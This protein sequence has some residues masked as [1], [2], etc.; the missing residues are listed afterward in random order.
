MR[1]V[2]YMKVNFQNKRILVIDDE[3][4]MLDIVQALLK[5]HDAQPFAAPG[6]KKGLQMACE[7]FD[8][9]ILDRYMPDGD[10]LDV[11]AKLRSDEKTKNT[12]VVMLTGEK[13]MSEIRKSI[14]AGAAGYIVKP[15]KPDSFLQQTGKVLGVLEEME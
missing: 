4:A 11:L 8:L 13:D 6:A 7:G 15:F 9:I 12:P 1:N 14:D 2:L 5:K 10:G 3:Q